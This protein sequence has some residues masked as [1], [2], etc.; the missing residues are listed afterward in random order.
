MKKILLV[1]CPLAAML[2]SLLFSCTS[3]IEPPPP[4]PPDDLEDSSSSFSSE[5]GSSSSFFSSESS[6]SSSSSSGSGSTTSSSSVAV[7]DECTMSKSVYIV[8]ETASANITFSDPSCANLNYTGLKTFS[9]E[10]IGFHPAGTVKASAN[11]LCDSQLCKIS[12]DC[13]AFEVKSSPKPSVTC[14][15]DKTKYSYGET[16]RVTSVVNPDGAT[17]GASNITGV[18]AFTAADEGSKP[19]GTIK[20]SVSCTY[21]SA[22]LPVATQ[23]CPAFTVVSGCADYS[24]EFCTT[25]NVYSWNPSNNYSSFSPNGGGGGGGLPQEAMCVK[26]PR[27]I[28]VRCQQ[29]LCKANGIIEIG[30]ADGNTLPYQLIEK[31]PNDECGYVYINIERSTAQGWYGMLEANQ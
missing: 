2:F 14:E 23:N 10:D 4:L 11:C 31:F 17:C 26:I 5:G 19:A 1:S 29:R 22:N 6:S 27:S 15:L 28:N 13:S 16:P 12:K 20:A 30:S 3:N 25:T 9:T 24:S 8:G 18:K 21:N 7:I